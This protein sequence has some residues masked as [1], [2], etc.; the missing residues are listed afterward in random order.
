MSDP[1]LKPRSNQAESAPSDASG[2]EAAAEPSLLLAVGVLLPPAAL[3]TLGPVLEERCLETPFGSVGP[4]A[5]RQPHSGP[6]LWLL[7]YTGSPM[8]TDPRATIY[9]AA[10]L[11]LSQLL[12]WDIATT[13]HTWL[14]R[15]Q[16]AIAADFIDAT[17][18]QPHT[19]AG[20]P[21]IELPE[22]PLPGGFC[23]RM[24]AALKAAL[25]LAPEV[26]Y[27]GIDGPQRETAAEARMFRTWA[28]D[29]VGQNLLPEARL[30]RELGLCCA[31]LVIV[32]S[33]AADLAAPIQPGE[34]R[35]GLGATLA[36]LPELVAA[37]TE[38]A[39]CGCAHP[40]Y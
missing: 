26:V 8:R 18:R 39:Q 24:T 12:L 33:Y 27:L 16:T 28:A 7:P 13:L 1:S 15:G 21:D 40:A 14:H 37:L 36:A 9:A 38:R 5:R 30:A 19:F 32:N 34:V 23:P 2:R 29:V 17:R 10:S 31:G 11:G 4:L 20:T 25:P 3:D 35:S 6:P 22:A